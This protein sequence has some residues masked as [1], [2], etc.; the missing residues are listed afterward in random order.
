M[1]KTKSLPVSQSHC[2]GGTGTKVPGGMGERR[3]L[4]IGDFLVVL[5]EINF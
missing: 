3:Q 1:S 2:V 5:R 4:E